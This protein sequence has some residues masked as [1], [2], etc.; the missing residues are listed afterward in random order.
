MRGG[1]KREV[2]AEGGSTVYVIFMYF[3][4]SDKE[5]NFRKYSRSTIDSLGT[6]YDYG[7]VMH[8]GAFAFSRNNQPTIVV[9]QTGVCKKQG[10]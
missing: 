5:S 4:I 6:P 10:F 1:R 7:S 8:Y 2:V 3:F 9:K